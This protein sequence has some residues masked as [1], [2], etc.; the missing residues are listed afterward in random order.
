MQESRRQGPRIELP[1]GECLVPVVEEDAADLENRAGMA[2]NIDVVG[3]N[4]HFRFDVF[5]M[6][7]AI[8]HYAI[9]PR[10]EAAHQTA[11]FFDESHDVVVLGP[12]C[13]G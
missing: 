2:V 5:K 12:W 7:A 8:G 11:I 6:C 3:G 1:F 10:G 4:G 13:T 9:G